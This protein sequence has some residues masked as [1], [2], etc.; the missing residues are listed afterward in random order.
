MTLDNLIN[1]LSLADQSLVLLRGFDSPHASRVRTVVPALGFESATGITIGAMLAAARSAQG[2]AFT[3]GYDEF[4]A[5]GDTPCWLDFKGMPFGLEIT[6]ELLADYITAGV[7]PR[8]TEDH[9]LST[10]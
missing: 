10:A 3:D 5:T 4:T 9:P 7:P 6:P 2:V 8:G 1:T